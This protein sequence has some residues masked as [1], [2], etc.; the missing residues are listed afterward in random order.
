MKGRERKEPR[1]PHSGEKKEKMGEF[2]ERH[3]LGGKDTE[4]R[5]VKQ[6]IYTWRR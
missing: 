1:K 4:K 2:H 5:K 6:A 3:G